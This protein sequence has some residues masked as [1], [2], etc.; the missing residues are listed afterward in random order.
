MCRNSKQG[1]YLTTMSIISL[2]ID[3]R[4]F[5]FV[6]LYFRQAGVKNKFFISGFFSELEFYD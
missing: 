1:H 3:K 5:M 2:T 6:V 4:A